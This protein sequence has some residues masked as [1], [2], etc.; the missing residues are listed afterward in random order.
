MADV[1]AA[2]WVYNFLFVANIPPQHFVEQAIHYWSL[3]IE[4]QFYVFIACLYKLF[5]KRGFYAIP[6]LCVTISVHRAYVGALGSN[7]T[8]N[9]VDD[10]LCGCALAMITEG[11][12]GKSLI[13]F[14]KRIPFGAILGL[15]AALAI[16]SHPASA[17]FGYLRPYIA[18]TLIGA[19][20]FSEDRRIEVLMG[21]RVFLYIAKISFA[22]YV[23]HAILV[24]T[25]L[26]ID[27]DKVMKYVKRIPLIAITVALSH[28]STFYFEKYFIGL[29]RRLSSHLKRNP[30]SART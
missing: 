12:L 30:V 14:L 23:I 20:I 10:I 27:E 7:I 29:G 24:H 22:L 18:A 17:G 21:S 11:M 25:W 3:C 28:F 5:G 13:G 1:G 2:S 6:L 4:V 16:S 26:G 9:R 8:W 15:L 19:S